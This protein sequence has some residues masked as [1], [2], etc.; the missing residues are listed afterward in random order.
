MG[1]WKAKAVYKDGSEEERE[2]P[3]NAGVLPGVTIDKEKA[4][5]TDFMVDLKKEFE[6]ECETCTV[7][8]IDD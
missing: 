8:Y 5:I 7:N 4:K 2:F 6:I 3:V 1:Y